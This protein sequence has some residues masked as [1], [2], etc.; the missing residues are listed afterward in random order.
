M[1]GRVFAEQRF[2]R[3]LAAPDEHAHSQQQ[4]NGLGGQQERLLVYGRAGE[5][6]FTC[7]RP[8]SLVRIAGRSSVFCR[9]CQR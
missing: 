4:Q 3:L 2:F 1:L 6:C 7:G 9:R 5:P 8:L